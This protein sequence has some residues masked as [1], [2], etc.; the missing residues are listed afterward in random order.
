L[1]EERNQHAETNQKHFHSQLGFDHEITPRSWTTAIRGASLQK[2][3]DANTKSS[4]GAGIDFSMEYWLG[5]LVLI[6]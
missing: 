6:G 2:M 1:K 3:S 4:S 5:T